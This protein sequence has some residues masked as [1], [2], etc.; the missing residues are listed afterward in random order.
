MEYNVEITEPVERRLKRF[1]KEIQR[2]FAEKVRKIRENP[3][4]FGKR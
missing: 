4:V 3:M 1:D 2:R